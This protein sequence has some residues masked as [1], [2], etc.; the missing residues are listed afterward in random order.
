MILSYIGVVFI[1]LLGCK[2]F[3]AK[4]IPWSR[5]KNITGVLGKILG[6]GCCLLAVVWFWMLYL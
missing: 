6:A 1:F 2:G 3:T 5:Q 4:G